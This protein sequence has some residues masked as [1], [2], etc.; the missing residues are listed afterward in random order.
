MTTM[1]SVASGKGGVGK[2]VVVGNLSL[3]FARSGRRVTVVDLDVGGADLHILFGLFHPTATLT[4]FLMR[5]VDSLETV[6]QV[7]TRHAELRLI[8]GTGETLASANMPYA[9]KQRLIRHLKTLQTDIILID[10]GAGTWYHALDFFLMADHHVA[11]TTPDP[12][13]VFGS[14]PIC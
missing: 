10:V 7:V 2:S 9:K 5:R 4:D 13:S 11:M 14:L 12:T 8:P 6:A 1:I 3:V